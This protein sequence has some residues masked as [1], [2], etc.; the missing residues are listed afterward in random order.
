MFACFGRG[1]TRKNSQL[2]TAINKC[3]SIDPS[4]CRDALYTIVHYI[5][6]NDDKKRYCVKHGAVKVIVD[7]VKK[8]EKLAS[9]G[10]LALY[11]MVKIGP[12]GVDAC[13]KAGAALMATETIM[14]NMRHVN[15]CINA[16]NL[17]RKLAQSNDHNKQ[18]IKDMT[19]GQYRQ[20]SITLVIMF[21][22]MTHEGREATTDEERQDKDDVLD[23]L[24]SLSDVLYD[25]DEEDEEAQGIIG[26][27]EEEKGDPMEY[28]KERN[29]EK[30]NNPR[31]PNRSPEGGGRRRR[32]SATQKNKKTK[33]RNTRKGLKYV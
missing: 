3:K 23:S 30:T 7:A 8:H 9:S 15:A 1:C 11:Y 21:A 18:I 16:S 14:N 13:M 24:N 31:N 19:F 22:K 17:I 26:M 29:A 20:F 28:S 2:D 5:K 4:V 12:E 6:E 33:R 10:C 27:L 25:D 32:K